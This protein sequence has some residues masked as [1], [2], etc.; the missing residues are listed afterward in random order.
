MRH[1]N[2]LKLIK[3][4]WSS[5]RFRVAIFT[6]MLVTTLEDVVKRFF[7][8]IP[9][10]GWDGTARTICLYGI[11]F[12]LK[13]IH[14]R[15]LI[16]RDL[17]AANILLHKN[18]E[19]VIGDFGLSTGLMPNSLKVGQNAAFECGTP[20]YMAQ[21]L[22]REANSG[23][24][25]QAVDVYSFVVLAYAMFTETFELDDQGGVWRNADEM[26]QIANGARWK[27]G[28]DIPDGW[29]NVITNCWAPSDRW[30]MSQVLQIRTSQPGAY[31]FLGADQTKVAKR[32]K[33]R[34]NDDG[35]EGKWLEREHNRKSLS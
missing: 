6:N 19:P 4:K 16:H 11:A 35:V 9:L 18:M 7:Q 24:Y 2:G 8:G 22:F 1:P 20:L 14:S 13:H 15:R 29:W 31:S 26:L 33:L 25:G 32:E 10:S 3:A 12:G 27:R 21:E 30:P 28:F 23:S 34:R 17:K 5:G